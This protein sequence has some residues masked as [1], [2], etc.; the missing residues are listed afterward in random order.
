MTAE[1]EVGR[2]TDLVHAY[3]V[4]V[5]TRWSSAL[6]AS[7]GIEAQSHSPDQRPQQG[8]ERVRGVLWGMAHEMS[9]AAGCEN[10]IVSPW[11]SRG[12][13]TAHGRDG[14]FEA[15]PGSSPSERLQDCSVSAVGQRREW[16]VP[17]MSCQPRPAAFATTLP[18]RSGDVGLDVWA[19]PTWIKDLGSASGAGEGQ[20][21]AFISCTTC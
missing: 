5:T 7:A 16:V 15:K 9:L 12:R 2:P 19:R 13:R 17:A 3:C 20:R 11:S 18:Q 8:R 14:E 6:T 21:G 1:C 10:V 4:P